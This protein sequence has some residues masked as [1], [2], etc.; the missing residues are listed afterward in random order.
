MNA[1][2][3]SH[4]GMGDNIFM[5]GALRFLL[6][7]YDNIYFLCKRCYYSNIKLFF[8]D[9]P[10]IICVPFNENN[11]YQNIYNIINYIYNYLNYDIFI[12]GVHKNYLKSKIT[13]LKFINSKISDE[14]Y[15]IDF[16][17]LTS[18][19]YNFIK[20][21]YTDINLNL[22][23]FYDYFYLPSIPDSLD[24]YNSVKQ[25]YIVFIQSKSSDNS[26]LNI[27][28]LIEKYIN[29]K[30]VILICNDENLYKNDSDKYNICQ[31][32]VKNKI[33]NYID[34]IKNSDEIYIIDSCFTGII[35]PL[36]K[37]NKLKTSKV[38]I[39][40]RDMINNIII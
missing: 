24:L 34:T 37:T 35:L 36:L 17:T 4:N 13:N 21:F 38:R 11:E 20:E 32:F 12:S 7:F 6:N 27:S 16:D 33:I 18:D 2:L 28:N 40:K 8:M 15:I 31:E 29:D 3:V 26:V 22:T 30:D 19:N 10:N 9:T 25:Y 14:K 39:I 5:I 1:Y 23:Y